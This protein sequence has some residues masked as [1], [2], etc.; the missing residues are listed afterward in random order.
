MQGPKFCAKAQI[1]G[2]PAYTVLDGCCGTSTVVPS[3]NGRT[4]L[5]DAPA[6]RSPMVALHFTFL[7]SAGTNAQSWKSLR[8]AEQMRG[9]AWAPAET[10]GGPPAFPPS[11]PSLGIAQRPARGRS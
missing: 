2:S 11:V 8:G 9:A 4:C 1:V 6:K 7:V 3:G 10:H 5:G